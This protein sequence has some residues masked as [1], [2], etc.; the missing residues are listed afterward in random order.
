MAKIKPN[1][2]CLSAFKK[3]KTTNFL[4]VLTDTREKIVTLSQP[5][6][7]N[8]VSPKSAYQEAFK[9]FTPKLTGSPKHMKLKAERLWCFFFSPVN[10]SPLARAMKA[11]L[12]MA[13]GLR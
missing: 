3:K 1:L 13:E 11:G 10:Q 5:A 12:K 7:Q 8:N 2:S 4:T 9:V 6:L